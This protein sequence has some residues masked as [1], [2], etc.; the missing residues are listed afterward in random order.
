M[1]GLRSDTS[2]NPVNKEKVFA[3]YENSLDQAVK[4]YSERYTRLDNNRRQEKAERR[5]QGAFKISD[6]DTYP[7]SGELIDIGFFSSYKTHEKDGRV[8]LESGEYAIY[9]IVYEPS[10]EFH[11]YRLSYASVKT[12]SGQDYKSFDEMVYALSVASLESE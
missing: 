3:E 6:Y 2:F 4:Y 12:L 5:R 10:G 8:T 9:N 1:S 7:P 11:C